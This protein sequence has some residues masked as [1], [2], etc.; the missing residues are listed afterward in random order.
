MQVGD[1]VAA[2]EWPVAIVGGPN[3]EAQ[4]AP[5]VAQ[6]ALDLGVRPVT[7]ARGPHAMEQAT[8]TSPSELPVAEHASGHSS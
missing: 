4:G 5:E 1:Q 8:A 2:A 6:P 7:D 3:I